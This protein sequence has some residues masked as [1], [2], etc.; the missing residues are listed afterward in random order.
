[1]AFFSILYPSSGLHGQPRNQEKPDFFSD[2]NLDQVFAPILKAKKRYELDSFF[3]SPL[4]DLD[5]SRY[6]QDIARELENRDLRDVLDDFSRNAYDLDRSLD[7]VRTALASSDPWNDTWLARGRFLD[8]A[9]RYCLSLDSLSQRLAS[10]A[11]V[12]EGMQ[13][14]SEYLRETIGSPGFR[15][16]DRRVRK[17]RDGFSGLRYCMLIR[18]GTIRVRKYEGQA[19]L[20]AR[21]M[22][23]F[24]KFRQGEAKDYRH[25]LSEEPHA[26]HVE[27]AVLG[28]LAQVFKEDFAD[29]DDFCSVHL[30][31][32]D[33]VIL[34]FSREVQ[35][36]LS[37]FEYTAPLRDAG[38]AFCYPELLAVP[39]R[40]SSENSFDIALASAAPEGIVPNSFSLEP[41]ERIIVVTG[42]NQGGKTT[43]ARMFGQLF[44][45]ASLGLCIPG[46][47]GVFHLP[48]RILT[49]FGREEDL[50]SLD[51]KLQDDLVRLRRLL[52]SVT[53]RSVVIINEIFS[54]TMLSD[55]LTLSGRMMDA[56]AGLGAPCVVVTFLDELAQH[57]SETVSMMSTV[58]EDEP[59]SRTFRIIRKPPDGLAYAHHIA[60]RHGLSYAQLDRRLKRESPIDVS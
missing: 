19:D 35:F 59:E 48:D 42:P 36:Y 5:T 15:E 12:S 56:L 11:L 45:L 14:F 27:A 57:G 26:A 2:L 23:I 37:W 33:P 39:G 6:R 18:S 51:G 40:L 7:A 25:K 16:L 60:M 3:Y 50:S 22:E 46:T 8:Y 13:G 55:A 10:F 24:G 21:T 4:Q 41:P 31:F 34:R 1:M 53:H 20:S 43:F 9:E 49:H 29:L 47:H 58:K 44:Y 30:R 28:M 54:S 17:L 38:L 32:D 52:G